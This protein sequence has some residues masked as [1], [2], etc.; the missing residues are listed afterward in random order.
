MPPELPRDA[1]FN[2]RHEVSEALRLL[3]HNSHAKLRAKK[4]ADLLRAYLQLARVHQQG[5][6]AEGAY[7]ALLEGEAWETMALSVGINEPVVAAELA[8][9]RARLVYRD[10]RG[11][12]VLLRSK[13]LS[14]AHKS[15]LMDLLE[16]AV[17][18]E[19][20]LPLWSPAQELYP[21]EFP[22]EV[23]AQLGAIREK[24]RKLEE[25]AKEREEAAMELLATYA[26]DMGVL[27]EAGFPVQA[28]RVI[29][30]GCRRQED[31]FE[32]KFHIGGERSPVYYPAGEFLEFTLPRNGDLLLAYLHSPEVSAE[33]KDWLLAH[34]RVISGLSLKAPR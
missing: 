31:E 9:Y 2:A 20:A 8:R 12:L 21:T 22:P 34:I 23:K 24:R 13:V 26:I 16:R 28:E 5:G 33:R 6:N 14:D 11:L 25:P 29:L 3:R 18:R 32:G 15:Y 17:E 10:G 7:Q 27:L 30:E 1:L 4:F 19:S